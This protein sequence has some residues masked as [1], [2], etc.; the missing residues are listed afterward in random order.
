MARQEKIGVGLVLR[1]AHAAAQLV[2]IGE[3]EAVGAVDDDRVRVGDIEAAFDD[4]GGEQ[5]VGFAGDEAGHHVLEFLRVHLAVAD[6]DPRLGHEQLELLRDFLDGV[7]AV[8]EEIDLAVARHFALDGFADDALVV[9]RDD[10]LDRMPVGRRGLDRAH[11]ARAGEREI[12]RARNRRGR[13][14]EHIDEPEELLEFF[15]LLH[16]EALLLVDDDEAE[17]LEFDVLREQ[18]VRAD[19]DI[20]RAV[21]DARDGRALALRRLQAA[22]AIDADRVG[23]VAL[24]QVFPVLL[25]EDGRRHEKRRLLAF[26]HRLETARIATSVL[27]K[28]TSPQ[29]S[30][31][32]GRVLSMSR[33]VSRMERSWSSVSS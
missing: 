12:K 13:K 6:D 25:G 10:G 11:V 26:L 31:S 32:I 24:A 9:G 7:D 21:L 27:P 2:E 18:P 8:V 19:D 15:L 5:H 29:M 23:G 1:A 20:D 14:R 33:F 22:Q 3:A 30:R 4:R 28:P 17:V 16:A